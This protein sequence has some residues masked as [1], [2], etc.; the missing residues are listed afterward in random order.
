MNKTDNLFD[1]LFKYDESPSTSYGF[2]SWLKYFENM[3]KDGIDGDEVVLVGAANHFQ[4]P[5]RIIDSRS[6][7]SV[8]Q[9]EDFAVIDP[10]ELVVGHVPEIHYVS[11]RSRHGKVFFLIDI[12][13]EKCHPSIFD[14]T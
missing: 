11:L 2:P 9:P 10:I 13:I 8:I 14:N 6:N 3:R 7:E 4:L 12:T 1:L 5:I